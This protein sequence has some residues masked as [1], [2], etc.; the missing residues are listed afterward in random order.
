VGLIAA[1]DRDVQHVGQA[2]VV[3]V[4]TIAGQQTRVLCALDALADQTRPHLGRMI[5]RAHW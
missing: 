3:H 4:S 2:D 1:P 5:A